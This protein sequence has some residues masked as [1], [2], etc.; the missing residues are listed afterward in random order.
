MNTPNKHYD[1]VNKYD[2]LSHASIYNT[3]FHGKIK[4]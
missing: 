2:L 4:R 1:I 3:Y